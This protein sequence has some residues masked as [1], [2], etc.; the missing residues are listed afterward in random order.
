VADTDRRHVYIVG[1]GLAGMTVAHELA[2]QNVPVTI[3]EAGSRL[4]GKAGAEYDAELDMW[5]DHGFHIFPAW[6]ANVRPLLTELGVDDLVDTDAQHTIT[7]GESEDQPG[8]WVTNYAVTSFQRAL[9]NLRHTPLRW[10]QAAI[11]TYFLIDLASKYFGRTAFLDRVSVNGYFRSRWYCHEDVANFHHF[12]GL[13]ASSIPADAMSAATFQ[14]V[15][16]GFMQHRNILV[17]MLRGDL[18]TRF[19]LPFQKRLERLGVRIVFNHPVRR[20]EVRDGRV[21]GLYAGS[22]PRI[23]LSLADAEARASAAGER[24]LSEIEGDRLSADDMFVL[25]TPPERTRQFLDDGNYALDREGL[26]RHRALSGLNYLTSDAMAALHVVFKRRLPHIPPWHTSMHHSHYGLSM[27]DIS[28]HWPELERRGQTVL[29]VIA[30]DFKGIQ[31]LSPERQTALILED[32]LSFIRVDGDGR[33]VIDDDDIVAVRLNS[34][35]GAPLFLNTTSAWYYRPDGR[36]EIPNLFVSGDYCRSQA[37]LT[38]M[39]SAVFSGKCTA[40]HVLRALGKDWRGAE[41]KRFETP[42]RLLLLGAKYLL[43]PLIAPIGLAY[44]LQRKTAP[45]VEEA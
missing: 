39:E 33:K 37:D 26:R 15:I 27:I 44:L 7:R 35:I 29:S 38:S 2:K 25:A 36:T 41:P 11:G 45:R 24:L 21:A 20:I 8:K 19:I 23:G 43:L 31:G 18:Q 5:L 30:A 1:G 34:N 10:H 22:Q 12:L 42:N 4:G 13:Q 6:Y 3:L 14:N 32:L 40:Q 17:G 9:H 28:Q 16:R